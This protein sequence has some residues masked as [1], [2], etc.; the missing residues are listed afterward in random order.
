[1]KNFIKPQ[2]KEDVKKFLSQEPQ[3]ILVNQ[4]TPA[5]EGR[6][7]IEIDGVNFESFVMPSEIKN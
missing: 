6:Y 1:M 7:K 2:N 3:E 4:I 5:L